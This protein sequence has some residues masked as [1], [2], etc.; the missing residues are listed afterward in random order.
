MK[1]LLIFFFIY[2]AAG[3]FVAL[4]RL[5]FSVSMVLKPSAALHSACPSLVSLRLSRRSAP[6]IDV[7]YY[8]F[9]LYSIYRVCVCV[10]VFYHM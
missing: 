8:T 9:D 10:C 1:L 6:L 3:C 7:S 5:S 4:D 2:T